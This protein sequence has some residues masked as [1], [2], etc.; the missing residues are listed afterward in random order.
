MATV[1]DSLLITLGLDTKEFK[2]GHKETEEALKKTADSAT[3]TQKT[4]SEQN[5]KTIESYAGVKREVM[6]LGLAIVASANGV[7]NFV[8]QVVTSDM[9]IV[10]LSK[11]V[12]LSAQQ[13][14]NWEGAG[15]R[16]GAQAGEMSNAFRNVNQ[17]MQDMR[18]K[19]SSAAMYPLQRMG[20][21]MAAFVDKSTTAEQRMKLIAAAMQKLSPQDRQYW[22]QQAGFTEDQ[23]NVLSTT[24]EKLNAILADQDKINKLDKEHEKNVDKIND[25]YTR[26]KEQF[27]GFGREFIDQTAPAIIKALDWMTDHALLTAIGIGGITLA[28]KSMIASAGIGLLRSL[29]VLAPAAASTAGV[30]AA[31]ASTAGVGAAAGVAA[32]AGV[33]MAL[34]SR[35]LNKGEDELMA[36][37]RADWK[38]KNSTPNA[39]NKPNAPNDPSAQNATSGNNTSTSDLFA[40]LEKQYGLPAGLMDSLWSQESGRGKHMRS[41][42]GAKGHFQFMDATAKQY[43]VTN[44]DDLSSSATGAAKMMRDLLRHYKNNLPLALS[45]YNWG[46]GN[47]DHKGIA[48]APLETRNYAPSIMTRMKSASSSNPVTIGTINI[49]T[50]A[51]DAK[52]VARD[53]NSALNRYMSTAQANTG[54]M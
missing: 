47:L 10:R 44:P 41:S 32:G 22:G 7:K 38:A 43:G 29:G 18:Q 49:Q 48:N 37:R 13:L 3:R 52:G 28:L 51:T 42:A 50:Q 4:T 2:K 45:A 30:G 54:M 24:S 53:L 11:N 36:K 17:I 15:K 20:V 8:A 21:D 25:A 33:G 14:S 6:A 34:Y 46:A 16:L 9:G 40:G 35:D 5:K 12:G 19:G 1:I 31:A 39:T 23:I 27:S 26:L